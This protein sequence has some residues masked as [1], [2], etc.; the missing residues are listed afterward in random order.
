MHLLEIPIKGQYNKGQKIALC[1]NTGLSTGAHLHMESWNVDPI[2][3][4]KRY[5]RVLKEK[6]IRIYTR[7]PYKEFRYEVDRVII[8]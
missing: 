8:N 1:G 7:D 4:S 5:S 6:D 3:V 2:N